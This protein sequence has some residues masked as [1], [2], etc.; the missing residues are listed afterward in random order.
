MTLTQQLINYIRNK[1]VSQNDLDRAAVLTLDAIANMLGGCNSKPGRKLLQWGE[2]QG[3]DAGRKAL[4]AGGLT[5]ILETDD[6]HRA[7]VTHPGC[8]VV[9]A[10]FALSLIHI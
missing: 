9:P 6:L 5:H 10:V 8:V 2:G 3:Q 7:S 4:I 1:P